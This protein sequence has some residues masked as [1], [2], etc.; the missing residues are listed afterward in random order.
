[1]R[2]E[3]LEAPW[4]REHLF[5]GQNSKSCW[6]VFVKIKLM[7]FTCK[8][9]NRCFGVWEASPPTRASICNLCF[10]CRPCRFLHGGAQSAQCAWGHDRTGDSSWG[11]G[12]MPHWAI[13]C[14]WGNS[15]FPWMFASRPQPPTSHFGLLRRTSVTMTVTFGVDFIGFNAI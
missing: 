4:A 11:P 1:M 12:N 8:V 9:S 15:L 10:S 7:H 2:E 3:C 6:C 5:R 13:I 14:K